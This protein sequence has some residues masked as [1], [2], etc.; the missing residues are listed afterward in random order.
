MQLIPGDEDVVIRRSTRSKRSREDWEETLVMRVRTTRASGG[1]PMVAVSSLGGQPQHK[2][3]ANEDRAE[4]PNEELQPF[5]GTCGCKHV[6]N[7]IFC[8]KC[9]TKRARCVARNLDHQ[10]PPPEIEEDEVITCLAACY[11]IVLMLLL[12]LTIGR[13]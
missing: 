2:K 4:T 3:N 10:S 13:S 1:S 5:C 9:G 6:D 11:Y 12:T 7:N 8:V